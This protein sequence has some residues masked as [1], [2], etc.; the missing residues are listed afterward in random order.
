M[1]PN[2]QAGLFG[3]V[4]LI[5]FV[6]MLYFFIFRPQQREQK[7]HREMIGNLKKNDE[8]VTLGGIHGTVIQVKEKTFVVRIDDSA[9]IEVD[10]SAISYV[11]K[12]R[13]KE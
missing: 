11:V 1:Q 9:K 2:P 3:I 13:Q 6:L 8:V 12:E 5:F 7:R 4:P 10:K